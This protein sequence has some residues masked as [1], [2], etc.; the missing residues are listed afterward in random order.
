MSIVYGGKPERGAVWRALFAAELPEVAFH[1][2]PETGDP[3]AVTYAATWNPIPDLSA[4]FPTLRVLFSSGAGVDQLDAAAL[5]EAVSLVRMVEPG[6]VDSMA[7]YV[8]LATL[9][10][11]RDLL[12]F[13]RRQ[14]EAVWKELP[15][16]TAASRRVG[17]MGLGT[18]G[19][20]AL[21]RLA[22]FGFA[23]R[24]WNRSP[25]AIAGVACY[26][27]A[28]GLDPFLSG[29]DILVC[30]LPLTG[31][32]RGI[33]CA[34]L[35]AKLPVGAC[36]VNVGRGGHLVEPDLVAALESGHLAGAVLDVAAQEPL[37][38][39]H[40]FWR[41]PRIVLTPHVASMT[42]P[43]SAGRVLLDNVRRHRRGEAMVGLVD[44]ARGY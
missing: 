43:E 15:V 16:R 11:H 22:P 23:L 13:A 7:E 40:P 42:Q 2:L 1:L 31:E 12:T 20:A 37:P 34:E 14:A 41:H 26:A 39:A 29:C 10:H 33:L 17:V 35:F 28:D 19:Q 8:A 18:L 27:G 24:G 9:L 4:R 36:L 21:A 38:S 30:L 32:T 44:R 5:P 6:I 25:R 3:A